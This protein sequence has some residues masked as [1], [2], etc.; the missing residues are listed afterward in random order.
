MVVRVWSATSFLRL[1]GDHLVW[2]ADPWSC[3]CVS[4]LLVPVSVVP[5]PLVCVVS[6]S[7][8]LRRLLWFVL[9]V[10]RLCRWVLL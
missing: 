5:S 7:L 3:C 9:F 2:V 8:S 10:F 4:L 1:V 6:L